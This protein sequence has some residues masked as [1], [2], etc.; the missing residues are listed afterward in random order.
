M[1]TTLATPANMRAFE[2]AHPRSSP[3][4]E[5]QRAVT[6][7]PHTGEIYS[8]GSGD[9]WQL[10]DDEPVRDALGEPMFLVVEQTHYVD[11][12]A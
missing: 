3:N 8:P 2:D 9:Y 5:P 7:S 6:F 1:L 4:V 10:P 11:A 12:L